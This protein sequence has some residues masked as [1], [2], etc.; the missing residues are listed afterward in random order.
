MR[1]RSIPDLESNFS[2]FKNELIDKKDEKTFKNKKLSL[3][4][5]K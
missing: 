5:I 2:L 1:H 3:P 4:F